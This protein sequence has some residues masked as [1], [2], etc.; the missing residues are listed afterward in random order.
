MISSTLISGMWAKQLDVLC[1]HIRDVMLGSQVLSHVSTNMMP[2]KH[3]LKHPGVHWRPCKSSNCNGRP[4]LGASSTF[5]KAQLVKGWMDRCGM[6]GRCHRTSKIQHPPS[7]S[8]CCMLLLGSCRDF[9][10]LPTP[11]LLH[12]PARLMWLC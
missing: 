2:E 9:S 12:D 3:K 10:P 7:L 5:W 11:F 6:C 1:L 4:P 8:S